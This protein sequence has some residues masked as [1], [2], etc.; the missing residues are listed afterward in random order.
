LNPRQAQNAQVS[1][2][3][4]AFWQQ[5]G[6]NWGKKKADGLMEMGFAHDG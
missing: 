3:G 4:A 1:T 5:Y 2:I 6:K